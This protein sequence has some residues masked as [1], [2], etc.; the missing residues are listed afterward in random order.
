M[1]KRIFTVCFAALLALASSITVFADDIP[2]EAGWRVTFDGRRM[3][4][5][6]STAQILLNLQLILKITIMPM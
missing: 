6:F 1:K 4:S 2:G 3:D 5:N